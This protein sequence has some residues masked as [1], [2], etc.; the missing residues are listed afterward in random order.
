[1]RYKGTNGVRLFHSARFVSA[2]IALGDPGGVFP[3][4]VFVFRTIICG[5]EM[6]HRSQDEEIGPSIIRIKFNHQS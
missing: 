3:V 1:M 4:F 2:A 6:D 5:N